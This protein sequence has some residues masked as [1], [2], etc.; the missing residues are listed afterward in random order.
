MM[1]K[2]V[3]WKNEPTTAPPVAGPQTGF[4][5]K[6]VANSKLCL[7]TTTHSSGWFILKSY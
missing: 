6:S 4:C 3:E 7:Q 1:K 5:S 2:I